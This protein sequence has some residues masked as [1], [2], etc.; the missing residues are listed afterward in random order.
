MT[1]PPIFCTVFFVSAR[2][3]SASP[4]ST[5]PA[6]FSAATISGVRNFTIGLFSPSSVQMM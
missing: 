5:L 3:K 2:K 4:G 1:A 6:C